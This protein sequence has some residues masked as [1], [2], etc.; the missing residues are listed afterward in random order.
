MAGTASPR[1]DRNGARKSEPV[2][3]RELPDVFRQ[4]PLLPSLQTVSVS[5]FTLQLSQPPFW[6]LRGF[7]ILALLPFLLQAWLC[8]EGQRLPEPPK[9]QGWAPGSR[10]RVLGCRAMLSFHT[11]MDAE[12]GPTSRGT[13]QPALAARLEPWEP[14]GLGGCNL[15]PIC[16]YPRRIQARLAAAH[17]WQCS[18]AGLWGCTVCLSSAVI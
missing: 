13:C 10:A 16:W 15:P 18:Y 14:A 2:A 1:Q 7:L 12:R 11:G 8:W 5:P 4:S 3:E 17:S 9:G 6:L